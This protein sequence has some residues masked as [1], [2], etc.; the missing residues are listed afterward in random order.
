MPR[1][2]H[3]ISSFISDKHLRRYC[4][5]LFSHEEL[6][7][8]L[9]KFVALCHPITE[10]DVSLIPMTERIAL[11]HTSFVTVKNMRECF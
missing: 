7:P 3:T 5:C 8:G 4:L 1:N 10:G 9:V 6:E 2:V 11:Y